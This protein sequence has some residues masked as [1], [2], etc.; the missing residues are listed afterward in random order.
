MSYLHPIFVNAKLFKFESI[1]RQKEAEA[2]VRSRPR[3]ID[4]TEFLREFPEAE[5][6]GELRPG[7]G[8]SA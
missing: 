6:A 2:W 3:P 5:P 1:E 8:I 7:S 4:L